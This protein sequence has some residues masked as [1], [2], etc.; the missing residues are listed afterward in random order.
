MR[1]LWHSHS[2][3]AATGYGKPTALWLPKLRDMGYEI[4]GSAFFGQDDVI[5]YQGIPVANTDDG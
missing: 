3:L 2:P 1:I 5:H 4:M